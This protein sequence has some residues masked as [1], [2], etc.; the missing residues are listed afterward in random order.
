MSKDDGVFLNEPF[1]TREV[2]KAVNQLH[3]KK[4]CGYDGIC[5]EHIKYGGNLLIITLTMIFNLISKT[6]Y[7]PVNFRRGTQ[8]PLFK[9][10]NLCS[11]DTNSYRGITLLTTFNKIY[12]MLIWGRL[13]LWWKENEVISRFQGAC[14]KGQSCVH[15]SLLLQET[16]SNALETNSKVFV[17]YFDVSKAFDTVWI[18]GLFYK[19]Y[20]IGV[21][22]KL[23]RIMY[24]TYIEFYC[25]VR[26]AGSS[27]EWFP[28]LCGIHQGGFLSLT[29]Y[30]TFI[31]DLLVDLEKSDL[32]C[33]ISRF[34]SSPAGYADD[35]ATATISKHRTDRVHTIVYEYGNKWR[36]TFN[37]A[38][39]AVMF[40]GEERKSCIENRK[41]RVFRLGKERVVE[42]E[43]YDHVG[44]K[45]CLFAENT[46][47]VE[48]KISKGRKT[49]NASTGLGIRKNGLNMITCNMIFWRVVVPT[50][51]FGCEV[52]IMS[53]RDEENLLNF[54]KYSGRR[55][56][57]FPQRS[58]SSSSFYGLGW[59]RLATYI[60]CKKLI[61][62][63][64]I[65]KMDPTNIIR[66]IFGLRFATFCENPRNGR[67]NKYRSP[68][69]DLLNVAISF[70]LFNVIQEM[71]NGTSPIVSKTA[72]SKIIW[73]RAWRLDDADWSASNFL[74]KD[75]DLLALTVGK[76]RY[77]SWWYISDMD[78]RYIKMCETMAKIICHTSRLKRDDFRLKG[79]P[80][81]TRTCTMCNMYCIED[82]L[83]LLT[84]C[85]FYHEDR[86]NMYKEI[87]K[88]CP[89]AAKSFEEYRGETP[90]FLLGRRIPLWEDNELLR[91]WCISGKA[92]CHMYNKAVNTRTGVG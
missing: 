40:F 64:T 70:G 59:L 37:A 85:P 80:M 92:I 79:S 19:L 88:E 34:P 42:K 30:I 18:N 20:Q 54:Q 32:C 89:N 31:N 47:R 78:Y 41:Y 83:H 67:T 8:V 51:T 84:Q 9:G 26:I 35:L 25:K 81:S 38:K 7:V 75:N 62:I 16:V 14:R 74:F 50:T 58:P 77:L 1:N 82:I 13:E 3:K 68:I 24:R 23:W 12:E 22:G 90:Y 55:V 45:M 2:Q 21:R 43:T 49:L 46:M 65:L 33:T 17:S 56:Q 10:K 73:E 52:W 15:T 28:M 60:R 29:K 27:S 48:E 36:F 63:L 76:T 86:D 87:F 57:R 71:I 39:S 72:W 66:Q 91:L 5:A 11:T 53:E 4:A 44:V 6:E 61:F 69:F